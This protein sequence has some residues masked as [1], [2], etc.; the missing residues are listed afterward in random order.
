MTRGVSAA[1]W[2][3]QS[4]QKCASVWQ[5]AQRGLRGAVWAVGLACAAFLPLQSANALAPT[6]AGA[7]TMARAELPPQG[8]DVLARI[9]NGDSFSH[10]KDG[11]VF[12]N[13]ERLL[14]KQTRGYYREYTVPTPGLTHRGAKRIVCGGEPKRRPDAC[15]YT[16]DHY[17]S[18]RLIAQ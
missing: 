11:S 2:S 15:Y 17:A 18:F 14:P 6:Q 5:R 1:A 16:E 13:R 12:G 10:P 3:T 4:A 8:R 9:E 7:P